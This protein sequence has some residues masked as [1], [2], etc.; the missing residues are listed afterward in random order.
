[1]SKMEMG[2]P[3]EQNDHDLLIALNTKMEMLIR[4]MGEYNNQAASLSAR[5]S[6]LETRDGRDSEK[7]SAIQRDMQEWIRNSNEVPALKAHIE[8]LESDVK[9]LKSVSNTWSILNSLG[10]GLVAILAWIFGK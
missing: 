1:M 8:S 2:M 5:V 4:S 3:V 9:A 6:V 10:I 7:F